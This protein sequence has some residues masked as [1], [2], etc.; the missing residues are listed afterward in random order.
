MNHFLLGK[1]VDDQ[2]KKQ[3]EKIRQNK[4]DADKLDLGDK[5]KLTKQE[6]ETLRHDKN[7][8]FM[9]QK[10]QDTTYEVRI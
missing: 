3:A 4:T 9:K 2:K 1:Y 10:C 8:L 7:R 6:R 5:I